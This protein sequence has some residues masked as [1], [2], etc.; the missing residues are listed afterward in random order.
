M[1]I[2]ETTHV[3]DKFKHWFIELPDPEFYIIVGGKPSKNKILW[4]SLVNVAQIKA[5]VQ[6]LKAIN[7]LYAD[8]DDSSVDDASRRIVECVND[9]T[10]SMLVKASSEDISSFQSYTIIGLDVSTKNN[11]ALQSI[12]S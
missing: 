11:R 1:E 9:T 10:N 3:T 2:T 4:Q 6:K 7:W 8:I 5:A 12:T